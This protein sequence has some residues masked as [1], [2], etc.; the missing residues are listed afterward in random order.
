VS[1]KNPNPVAR[2]AIQPKMAASTMVEAKAAGAMYSCDHP[3]LRNSQ[4]AT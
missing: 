3:A 1:I 2:K 4:A